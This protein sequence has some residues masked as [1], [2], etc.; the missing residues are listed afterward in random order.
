MVVQLNKKRADTMLNLE[1]L[2]GYVA[3]KLHTTIVTCQNQTYQL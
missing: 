2:S 1:K 3:R